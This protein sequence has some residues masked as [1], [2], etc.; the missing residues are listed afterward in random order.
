MD[1]ADRLLTLNV[2]HEPR[3]VSVAVEFVER[4]CE[5]SLSLGVVAARIGIPRT[6]LSSAFRRFRNTSVGAMIREVRVRRA[7]ELLATTT[8]PIQA[9]AQE[10]GFFDQAHLTRTFRRV[11]GTTPLDFRRGHRVRNEL[12]KH[13]PEMALR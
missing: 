9:I 13:G 11:T 10:T 1:N 12:R 8:T 6:T 4:Y 2:S 5:G 3:W 7:M